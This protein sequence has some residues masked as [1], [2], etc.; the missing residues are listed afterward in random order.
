MIASSFTV[1]GFEP[2]T[3]PPDGPPTNGNLYAYGGET[4]VGLYWTPGDYDAETQIAYVIDPTGTTEP[5]PGDII[6]LVG[7][8][9][10]G[11]EDDLDYIE[12]CYY[13]VRHRRGGQY[14]AWER[15]EHSF[16]CSEEI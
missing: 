13:W 1:T 3:T 11:F 10:Q 14:S 4:Y 7:P 16:G 2:S 6:G 15:C 5:S 12:R 8:G 9:V